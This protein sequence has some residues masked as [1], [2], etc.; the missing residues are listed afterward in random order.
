MSA[1]FNPYVQGWRMGNTSSAASAW[2]TPS[3]EAP[4]IFGALP[5]GSASHGQANLPLPDA[6]IFYITSFRPNI[7]NAS[8]VDARGRSCYRIVTEPSQPLSTAYYDARR[9]TVA[10]VDWSGERPSVEIPGLAPKQSIRSWLR[11]MP[12]RACVVVG[13]SIVCACAHPYF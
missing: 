13:G 6:T 12:D 7:L 5:G 1:H 9:R 8:V 4:S 11:A 2:G 3:G 10:V